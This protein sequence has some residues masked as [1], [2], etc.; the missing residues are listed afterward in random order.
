MENQRM[1]NKS[2]DQPKEDQHENRSKGEEQ[3]HKSKSKEDS[4][5]KSVALSFSEMKKLYVL[6]SKKLFI[7]CFYFYRLA[8][9]NRHVTGSFQFP[10]F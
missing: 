1:A 3:H 9:E 6:Y 5:L 4:V 7:N 10:S 2:V 8:V